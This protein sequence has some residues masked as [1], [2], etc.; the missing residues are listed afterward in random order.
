MGRAGLLFI[1]FLM[2]FSSA[3]LAVDEPTVPDDGAGAIVDGDGIAPGDGSAESD[4]GQEEDAVP[5]DDLLETPPADTAP[6]ETVPDVVDV[7]PEEVP[8]AE[9]IDDAPQ[10]T[11][12]EVLE[13]ADNTTENVTMP[14]E[15]PENRPIQL[16]VPA[17]GV[18]KSVV[19]MTLQ[20]G[21]RLDV[22]RK[23]LIE[24]KY[25]VTF[26]PV[27]ETHVVMLMHSQDNR[28][29][30]R[31]V[32]AMDGDEAKI[33]YSMDDRSYR[34]VLT[35]FTALRASLAPPELTDLDRLQKEGYLLPSGTIPVIIEF[36][37]SR[38][39]FDAKKELL[40]LLEVRRS[41]VRYDLRSVNGVS[42]VV[43]PEQIEMLR[44]SR[45]VK[46]IT[47]D[48]RV[49]F[50]LDDSVPQIGA[51]QL[52]MRTDASGRNITGH[53]VTI[54]VVDTGVDYTHPDLGGCFGEGCKVAAGYDFV[55]S[56]SNPMDDQGH[57]THVAATAAGNGTLDGVAPDATIIAYKVLNRQGSG[58]TSDIIAA[59]EHAADPDQDG[60]TSD[61]Y[62]IVSMSLGGWG[63]DDSPLSLAADSLVEKGV[64]VVVAAGNEGPSFGSVGS[65]ASSRQAISVAASCKTA[66]IGVDSYCDDPIAAFSSRGPTALGHLKPDIAAPG[67][68][69]CAAQYG[70]AWADRRCLDSRHV[71]ISGTSMA[72]PH[73]SGLIALLLQ[74]H[75]AWSPEDVKS[76]LITTAR[77]LGMSEFAQGSGEVNATAATAA[78][79]S[80]SPAP[81]SLGMVVQNTSVNI[82]ITN[83]ENTPLFITLNATNASDE[84]N[85]SFSIITFNQTSFVLPA[86][87]SVKIRTN[88][89]F[90]P[91]TEGRLTGDI[92]VTANS[93]PYRLPYG[94]TRLS[95]LTL[96]VDGVSAPDLLVHNR[97]MSQVY[98]MFNDGTQFTQKTMYVPSGEY[99]TYMLGEPDG[100]Y[101]IIMNSTT[102]GVGENKSVLLSRYS[103]RPFHVNGE[104]PNGVPMMLY[105]WNLGVRSYFGTY[106][107][108]YYS[109]DVG[110]DFMTAGYGDKT[111]YITP[112]PAGNMTTDILLSYHGVP[113][114]TVVSRPW[115]WGKTISAWM[116]YLGVEP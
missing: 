57:G 5:A 75:P 93:S 33:S 44:T 84:Q 104:D 70:T 41:P 20:Q 116:A 78:R 24:S 76:A 54:A 48:R 53:D 19:P 71:A 10:S 67:H 50:V 97:N 72:T 36:D 14:V 96:I 3:A 11:V 64:V 66:D 22:T 69:I 113:S 51:P 7:V 23:Y 63:D 34:V 21:M 103:G 6:S 106:T 109:Q 1:L 58:Y 28:R 15:L 35:N 95:A 85:R 18:E 45:A 8:P 88:I 30:M 46:S 32:F 74:E 80:I 52:W 82:T 12:D 62:D 27:S 38:E 13:S 89:N 68:L 87:A 37:R 112:K 56:D 31:R 105:E 73:V 25:L 42:A 81:L 47:L 115:G 91:T 2:L 17:A 83:L 29:V 40:E 9:T 60:N 49:E 111:V 102:I 65:P 92:I 4:A 61:H 98:G 110:Y 79:I 101:Y 90:S 108:A 94:L 26:K 107:G 43:T 77:D 99:I 39:F 55:N 114:P 16:P 86:R 59:M 100:P